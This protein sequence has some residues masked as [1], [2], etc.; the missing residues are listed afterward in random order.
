MN[1]KTEEQQDRRELLRSAARNL[2]LGGLCLASGGL[3]VRAVDGSC[4]GRSGHCR[5]CA[6]LADCKLPAA[7][8][9]R[10]SDK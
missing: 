4:L 6:K 3:I 5:N 10:K 9:T 1:E 7:V 8:A 2:A